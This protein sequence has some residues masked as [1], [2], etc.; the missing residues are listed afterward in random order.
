MRQETGFSTIGYS[1]AVRP[2][3]EKQLTAAVCLLGLCL[4]GVLV[5][6]HARGVQEY[7]FWAAPAEVMAEHA[8]LPVQVTTPALEVPA[9]TVVLEDA[10]GT[11]SEEIGRLRA[12][13][14]RLRA[15]L[16]EARVSSLADRI[17][18]SLRSSDAPVQKAYVLSQLDDGIVFATEQEKSIRE[19]MD[20]SLVWRV[21]T[22]G[23]QLYWEWQ[24]RRTQARQARSSDEAFREWE[25][26]E[27]L[28]AR[29]RAYEEF[30][31]RTVEWGA[32]L[33]LALALP[34]KVRE[35]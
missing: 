8:A 24:D 33:A 1:R 6:W 21:V 27:F 14:E 35:L 10:V 18:E 15:L 4:G 7:G 28:P 2:P 20:P 22:E 31:R 3:L 29:L 11:R 26:Q 25:R 17:V 12:E 23:R 32:P 13:N 19:T 9:R 30:A 34:E 16:D 5:G